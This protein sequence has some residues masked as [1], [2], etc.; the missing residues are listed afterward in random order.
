MRDVVSRDQE[1]MSP[2]SEDNQMFSLSSKTGGICVAEGV[3]ERSG[4]AT[5]R[6]VVIGL[7]GQGIESASSSLWSDRS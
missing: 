1:L 2:T 4:N 6:R 5:S 3:N 7:V